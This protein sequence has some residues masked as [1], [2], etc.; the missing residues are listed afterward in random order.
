MQSESQNIQVMKTPS[1]SQISCRLP[2]IEE[3]QN[4]RSA[5]KELTNNQTNRKKAFEA[6]LHESSCLYYVIWIMGIVL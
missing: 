3:E 6:Y 5:E 2:S 4:Y 1:G